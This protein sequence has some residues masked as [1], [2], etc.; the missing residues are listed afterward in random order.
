MAY[1]EYIILILVKILDNMLGTG[2]TLLIQQGRALMAATTVVLSQIIF[3]KI[4]SEIVSSSNDTKMLVVSI[5]AGV[6]TYMAILI[7]DKFS[8]DK[9]FVQNI[10]SDDKGAMIELSKFLRGN[11]IKN[12]VT[13][14]YTKEWGKTLAITIYSET[15]DESRLVDK[16]IDE[17]ENK[18]LRII[19]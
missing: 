17:S 18:Y 1:I 15:K 6:G 8:K 9:L 2:K 12:L 4:V 11:K 19:Q 14:S 7:N 3:F 13:D 5:S 10:L 16:F